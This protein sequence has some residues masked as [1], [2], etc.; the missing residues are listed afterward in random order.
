M[1]KQRMLRYDVISFSKHV[2]IVGSVQAP[3]VGTLLKSQESEKRLI[4]CI[5][6]GEIL[7]L[8]SVFN[9][10]INQSNNQSINLY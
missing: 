2:A 10:S 9:R 5:C 8:F 1:N 6:A 7:S 3:K 4:A